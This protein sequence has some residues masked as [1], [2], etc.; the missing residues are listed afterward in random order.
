MFESLISTNSVSLILVFFEGIISF[1]SPCV[2]PL[3]PVYISFLAGNAKQ[4]GEDGFITYQ[5]KKVFVNTVS[6]VLGISFAFFVL[7]MSFSALRIFFY[8]NKLLFTRLGGILIIMLGLFQLEVFHI[9]LLRRDRKFNL[10]LDNKKVNPLLAFIMGFTFSFAW[11]PC[12]GPA[13]SSVLILASGAK[14]A[15][16]GNMLVLIYAGGFIIPFLILGLF[17]TMN[18]FISPSTN[19]NEPEDVS[20]DKTDIVNEDEVISDTPKGNL[21][22]PAPD[23]T[24]MDQYGN[25]HTLSDYKGKVVFLNF[26]A[27][28]C[29]PCQKEMPHIEEL[30]AEYNFNEDD[31]IILGVAN[32]KSDD[33]PYNQDVSQEEIKE[34][35]K[36]NEYTFP[37]VFDVTG[38]IFNKYF[39]QS[40][41]TTFMID[42]EGNIKGYVTGILTKGIMQ[43]VIQETLDSAK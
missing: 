23:F 13:L 34:F 42:K 11:T 16:T 9:K 15:L 7:G 33:Y 3:I 30:Y 4:V 24:L 41:P 1:F 31:V 38:E 20:E 40:F 29:P 10:N 22:Y 21:T 6:F 19:E 18:S 32:P 8:S 25:E 17:T 36:D 43:N 35:L 14:S 12:V 27:T 2:I 39:I 26:W 37:V 28:W 5:R